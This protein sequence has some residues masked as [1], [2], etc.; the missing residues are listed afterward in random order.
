MLIGNAAAVE[1]SN[2]LRSNNVRV[3]VPAE[4][5]IR[6]TPP[7]GV[8]KH[9][10]W[11]VPN[12]LQQQHPAESEAG[13]SLLYGYLERLKAAIDRRA[14]KPK[15]ENAVLVCCAT[16]GVH[17]K[18]L[19]TCLVMYLDMCRRPYRDYID[20]VA[21]RYDGTQFM[22]EIQPGRTLAGYIK[23]FYFDCQACFLAM[24]EKEQVHE[25][26]AESEGADGR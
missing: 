23:D 26:G 14:Y 24:L 11:D 17:S 5:N 16:A 12:W 1:D 9:D 13:W 10:A 8:Y 25:S 21:F 22:E 2:L 6:I 18:Y 7:W 3:I 20:R 4:T 19:A 15:Q